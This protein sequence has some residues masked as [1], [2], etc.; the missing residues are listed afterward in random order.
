MLFKKGPDFG[1]IKKHVLMFVR[2][3]AHRAP[4]GALL[5]MHGPNMVFLGLQMTKLVFTHFTSVRLL[6]SMDPFV[7]L[8]DIFSSFKLKNMTKITSQEL[9][10]I[11]NK[12]PSINS[13][14]GC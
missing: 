11:L 14:I 13:K 10:S 8:Q 2:F 1:R 7:H 12:A 5:L 9:F 6:A 3:V 4:E